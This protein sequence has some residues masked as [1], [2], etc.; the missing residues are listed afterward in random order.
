MTD[1]AMAQKAFFSF[2]FEDL[3]R[4]MVVR[5]SWV[6]ANNTVAGI[7]GTAEFE[8]LE[9]EGDIAIMAWIDDRLADT[10]VTVVL[11]TGETSASRWM[12]Y[13]IQRSKDLGHGLLGI[14]IS[15][16]KDSNGDTCGKW[17]KIPTGFPYYQWIKDDG[18]NNIGSWIEAA[19]KDAGR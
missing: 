7:I 5:D 15:S 6:T 13:E 1:G 14:G 12:T 4:A 11:L 10:T 16:I 18:L 2:N 3:S 8:A 9:Q 17:Y 19:A